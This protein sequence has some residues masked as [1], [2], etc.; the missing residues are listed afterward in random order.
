MRLFFDVVLI[1]PQ[2]CMVG[3]TLL[4]VQ[5]SFIQSLDE[6][7]RRREMAVMARQQELEEEA[8]AIRKY[9][10]TPIFQKLG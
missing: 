10:H 7:D 6:R 1:Y 5:N 2:Q 8:R 4:C 3:L 9:I